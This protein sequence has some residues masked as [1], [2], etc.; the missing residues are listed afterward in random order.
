MELLITYARPYWKKIT[1]AILAVTMMALAT[2][3]QPQFLEKMMAAIIADKSDLILKNGFYLLLLALVGIVAGVTGTYFAS[4]VSQ[5]VAADIRQAEYEKIQQFSL[6]QVQSYS[7]A[8]LVVRLT[9]DI[10]QVQQLVMQSLQM[11]LRVPILFVGAI[12]LSIWTLPSLWWVV[13]LMIVLIVLSSKRIFA[14]MGRYFGKIQQLIDQNNTL[15]QENLSG[16]RVVKSFNQQGQE[17]ASFAQNTQELTDVN[18]RIGY[19]FNLM[20]PIF[21]L[22]SY[23]AIAAAMLFISTSIKEAPDQLA[24]ITPFITYLNQ[25]LMALLMLGMIS[26]FASRGF[27]SLKRIAGIMA[28]KTEHQKKGNQLAMAKEHFLTKELTVRDVSFT[29]PK[30]E[31]AVLHDLSFTLP[32]GQTLGVV[33]STGSGKSTLALLLARLYQADAGQI[34]VDGHAIEEIASSDWHQSV[35]IVMQKPVLFSGTIASNLKMGKEDASPEE[36][37]EAVDA[38]QAADFVDAYPDGLEHEIAERSANLS[39][40]QKQRLSLAR[41]LVKKPRLLILDDATSALDARSERRVQ[42]VLANDFQKT[43]KVI[44]AEKIAS[45]IHADQIIVLDAGQIVGVGSHNELLSN[46]PVYR[47]IYQSQKGKGQE[48]D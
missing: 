14:M 16:V 44:I 12:I 37:A 8:N 2:L 27:V 46:S 43:T 9:N 22:I 17:E 21:M 4:Q 25:I 38:A 34:T 20:F 3:T 19:L 18:R 31:N 45:I 6:E 5:S 32:A 35:A 28:E 47:E 40:G 39:G 23:A 13:L 11:V 48:N 1:V 10:N 24:K 30:A 42:D 33:G 41:A 36:M 29:Y 15:A 7:S 26:T